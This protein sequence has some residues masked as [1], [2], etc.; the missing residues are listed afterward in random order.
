MLSVSRN[1][2]DFPSDVRKLLRQPVSDAELAASGEGNSS[3]MTRSNGN[4]GPRM[5]WT[6]K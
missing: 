3:Y 5:T 6:G 1:V 2:G 4:K